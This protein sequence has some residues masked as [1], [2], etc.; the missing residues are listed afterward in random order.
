MKGKLKQILSFLLVLLFVVSLLPS[1][2]AEEELPETVTEEPEAPAEEPEA[3]E[4]SEQPAPEKELPEGIAGM[5]KDYVM[6]ESTIAEKQA[7]IDHDVLAM[8]ENMTPGKDYVEDEVLVT[9]A[10][11]EEATTIAAAYNAEL[12]S[13]NGLFAVLRLKTISVRDAVAAG[14]D[15]QLALPPVDPNVIVTLDPVDIV[16]IPAPIDDMRTLDWVPE[17][18]DWYDWVWNDPYLTNPSGDYQYMHDMV[19]SY[20]AWGVSR[21]NWTP[22]VAVLDT[23]VDYKHEDLGYIYKGKDCVDNDYDPMDLNGHGTHCAGIITAELNN[24]Y[25]GAGVAPDI[26]V[27]AVRVL[28]AEGSGETSWICDGIKYAADWGVDAIS[29]SLSGPVYTNTEQNAVNYAHNKN[30]TVIAAMGNNGT[31]TKRY[32]AAYDNVI[33]VA[34]VNPS[35][36]RAPYSNY[37][38]WCDIAAPGSDIWSTIPNNGYACWDGTSMATPVVAAAV[39]LYV[40]FLG[41]NPGPAQVEKALLA[42]TNKC[43]SKECG[44]GI[45]DVS[46]LISAAGN[47]QF[48][49][50]TYYLEYDEDDEYWYTVLDEWL[51]WSGNLNNVAI[52][53]ETVLRLY[54]SVNDTRSSIVYTVDGSNPSVANGQIKNGINSSEIYMSQ[55]KPGDNVTLKVLY[56]S[57]MGTV[58]KVTTYKFTVAPKPAGSV[59]S[60]DIS[61]EVLAPKALIPGKSVTVSAKVVGSSNLDQRVTW[62]ISANSGCPS[63]KI[64][65]KTGKLTTKAGETGSVT[66]RAISSAYK[67][68]IKSVKI[69][70]KQILPIGTIKLDTTTVSILR[71]D[72]ATIS[73]STLLDSQKN[74]VALSSRTYRW[75]SSN[76]SIAYVDYAADGYCYV[77]GLKKGTVTITCEVLDGSGKKASCK[78]TVVQPAEW[79]SV[80]GLECIASGTTATYKAVLNPKGCSDSVFWYLTDA[81]KGVTIDSAKG[82]VKVPA[83]IKSG[84][85]EVHAAANSGNCDTAFP[86]NIVSSKATSVTIYSYERNSS[87]SY[88]QVTKK[89]GKVTAVTMYS[90]NVNDDGDYENYI[91][92]K[93]KADTKT[94]LSWSSSNPNVVSVGSDGYVW[95]KSAGS[96]TITCAALD[97]SGKKATC[98]VTVVNPVSQ[99]FVK[100]KNPSFRQQD[101]IFLAGIGKSVGN[102]AVFGTTYGTPT[103]KKVTWSFAVYQE[104][105]SDGVGTVQSRGNITSQAVSNGWVKLSASGSLTVDKKIQSKWNS[106]VTSSNKY[107]VIYVYAK[108]QDG[109]NV[110]GTARYV[111]TPLTQKLTT[112]LSNNTITLKVNNKASGFYVYNEVG[113]YYG[114]YTITSSNPDI[115]SAIIGASYVDGIYVQV[116]SGRKTGTAKITFKANDGSNKSVTVTVKV[117]N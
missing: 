55:F 48:D 40:S 30:V 117:T 59:N 71:Y 81:P 75:T 80:T 4:P 74:N 35:G 112:T 50:Y 46:K 101:D 42:A 34:A 108:S 76:P 7:L 97:G 32:P 88:P 1:A 105:W 33:A 44:K 17:K 56:I 87:K 12:V 86:V 8:L 25:G 28:D 73:I 43:S 27:L 114:D 39:G 78:V 103:N 52:Y 94:N 22:T 91:I 54:T 63:A 100:S 77:V 64:D 82:V 85:F 90:V 47:V 69:P 72:W 20:A 31:N 110:T 2:I 111:V 61:V 15:L 104:I 24:G 5:P 84:S 115:A 58:S 18:T 23:G 106:Y 93:G 60:D 107:I 70:V 53:P 68:K 13:F 36:E 109:T 92:L 66:V 19:N 14:M 16:E 10:T 9:A 113:G 51:G 116:R 95:A 57:G 98:K 49:V 96:A 102:T 79:I 38:K 21:G 67:G 26:D 41:Y 83:N 45:I 65:A 6:S 99:I 29:M 37:G 3:G 11:E 62:I 89:D